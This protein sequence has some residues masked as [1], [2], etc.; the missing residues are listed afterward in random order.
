MTVGQRQFLSSRGL[1]ACLWGGEKQTGCADFSEKNTERIILETFLDFVVSGITKERQ[2]TGLDFK[3][4]FTY[5]TILHYISL[6][7][8]S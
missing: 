2:Q 4:I 7:F 3:N 8:Q 5:I 6:L 1:S